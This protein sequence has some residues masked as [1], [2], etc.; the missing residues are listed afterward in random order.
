MSRFACK[1]AVLTQCLFLM[2]FG[3]ATAATNRDLSLAMSA[4]PNP[5]QVGEPITYTLTVANKGGKPAKKLVVVN[6]LPAGT[7][8]FSASPD[9]QIASNKAKNTSRLICSANRLA[10]GAS[11]SWSFAVQPSGVGEL[12]NTAAVRSDKRDSNPGDNVFSLTTPILSGTNAPASGQLTPLSPDESNTAKGPDSGSHE[13]ENS[14]PVHPTADRIAMPDMRANAAR[15][16]DPEILADETKA[17]AAANLALAFDLYSAARQNTIGNFGFSVPD[18]AESL[19]MLAAGAEGGTL[20]AVLE[21]A[22]IDLLETRLHP[23]MNAATLDLANRNQSAHLELNASLWG[24]GVSQD[25][26]QSYYLFESRYLESLEKSHGPALAAEDFTAASGNAQIVTDI[27]DPWIAAHT[28]SEITSLVGGALSERT[29]LVS[30]STLSLNGAWRIPPD[31][32]PAAEGRFELLDDTQVLA[33]MLSFTGQFAY[34]EGDGY[35]AFELPLAGSDLALWVLMPDHGR[36]TEFQ[37]AFNLDQLNTIL[38]AMAPTQKTVH[39][40]KLG[41]ASGLPSGALAPLNR[42]NAFTEGQAD[43]SRINGEGYLFLEHLRYGSIVSWAE[44]G[45]KAD[46]ATVTIHQAT[47]DEPGRVWSGGSFFAQNSWV[48]YCNPVPHYDPSL[49]LARPFLFAIRDR[50]TGAILFMGQLT[51]PGGNPATPDWTANPCQIDF[52]SGFTIETG[53]PIL[54]NP[55]PQ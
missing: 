44:D 10:P 27:I 12:T 2:A 47:H 41:I 21:A 39:L 55:V 48:D 8:L 5:A 9:C 16:Y 1:S 37:S 14:T 4:E 45:A 17:I 19:A 20:P 31:A 25:Q 51:N 40:P 49:A 46:A 11:L 35:R 43:F 18:I 23:A 33:P 53:S 42:S 22:R 30:A 7:Q 29:R 15:E 13:T 3:T 26:A 54:L 6:P 28:Q 36:F 52:N 50:V 24:Q 34:A 38:A 32:N